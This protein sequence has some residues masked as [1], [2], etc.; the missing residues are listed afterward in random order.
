MYGVTPPPQHGQ[1]DINVTFN[2][3]QFLLHG[4]T[5]TIEID[6]YPTTRPWGRYCFDLWPGM[7]LLRVWF[8]YLFGKAG[9]GAMQFPV[10]AGYATMIHYEPPLIVHMSGTL[11]IVGSRPLGQGW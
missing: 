6:G 2:P 1:L 7:H 11:R 8:P 10:H 5:P 9:V 3:T 4:K